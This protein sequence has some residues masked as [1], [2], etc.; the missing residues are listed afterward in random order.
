MLWYLGISF[1]LPIKFI[2]FYVK[3]PSTTPEI[4]PFIRTTTAQSLTPNLN[5]SDQTSSPMGVRFSTGTNKTT[6]D[7]NHSKSAKQVNLDVNGDAHEKC[8]E[9]CGVLLTR[10]I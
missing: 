1:F 3:D 4:Q 8:L 6:A 9:P 10:Y 7:S 2:S 5:D